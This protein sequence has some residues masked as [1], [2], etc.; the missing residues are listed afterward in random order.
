MSQLPPQGLSA[1]NTAASEEWRALLEFAAPRPHPDR[2]AGLLQPSF[3]WPDFLQL[4]EE[5]GLIP[6]VAEHLTS[7][8]RASIPPASRLRLQD[9][10]RSLTM[11]SLQ[12]T[13]ELFGVLEHFANSGIEVL[14]TKGPALAVRCYGAPA[15][16]QYGDLDLIVRENHI[17]GSTQA[18]LDLGF[19]PR[20]PL[21]A[22][23][24]KKRA[25]E[26]A[27]RKPGSN[28]LVELHTEGTFRYHPRPLPI[29]KLFDRRAFVTID[30]RAVPALSLEDEL[31]LI[32][33]HGAKHF[34]E[35]L[36]WI[37]DV[38]ALISANPA[39]DWTRAL[40]AAREVGAERIL[41]LGLRLAT[42]V[43][44]ARLPA[45][46][47]SAVQSDRTAANLAARVIKHL[48]PTAAPEIGLVQRALF[49]IK[50]RGGFF[51]GAAYLLRLSLSPTEEDWTPG[52]AASRPALLDA[53]RRP[54]RLARK[55]RRGAGS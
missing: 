19:E 9:L 13:A 28:T 27:F 40:A 15:M 43:L 30:G 22:I 31:I 12:L 47:E 8:D 42:D 26:Y 18:M 53:I 3:N 25:G 17:R 10:Q 4:A 21:S 50:M 5:H 7:I 11:F 1:R 51:A 35:R 44:G 6:L 45:P 48:G 41:F 38:A 46:I 14:L 29:Q 34:W 36:M 49:R 2:L 20:I 54:L 52:S 23:D 37:A 24:G 39:L 16:R 33:V 55:H 32:C